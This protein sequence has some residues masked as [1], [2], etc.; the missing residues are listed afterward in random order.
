MTSGLLQDHVKRVHKTARLRCE[1]CNKAY[2]FASNLKEHLLSDS[3][4]EKIGG[5]DAVAK[6]QLKK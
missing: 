3:H 5:A 2:K 4:A 1:P 6:L